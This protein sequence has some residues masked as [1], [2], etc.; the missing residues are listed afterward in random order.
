[1]NEK[2]F[3]LK[4]YDGITC[5]VFDNGIEIANVHRDDAKGLVECLNALHEE[6]EELK[7]ERD[8]LIQGIVN[9]AKDGAKATV[10]V[11][12]SKNKVP[13]IRKGYYD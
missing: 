2:R 4:P 8:S 5:D 12:E 6:N 9:T 11:W 7:K 1:M 3:T 13:T 10:K